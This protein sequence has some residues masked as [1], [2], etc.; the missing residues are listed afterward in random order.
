ML[1][2]SF[3]LH[4][5]CTDTF[6]NYEQKRIWKW[7]HPFK[8]NLCSFVTSFV[9]CGSF[10]NVLDV[11]MCVCQASKFVT[12]PFLTSLTILFFGIN[13]NVWCHDL[14]RLWLVEAKKRHRLRCTK[15]EHDKKFIQS[16]WN[17]IIFSCLTWFGPKKYGTL[18]PV[19]FSNHVS[20]KT[21]Y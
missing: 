3:P 12:T 20:Q 19:L 5:W 10:R 2:S 6:H 11:Q 18:Y 17:F 21:F 16:L 9:T 8:T 14:A 1:M 13:S 4:I 7:L 15:K